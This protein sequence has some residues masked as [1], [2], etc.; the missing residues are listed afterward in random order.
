MEE[1][2]SDIISLKIKADRSR[3]DD[4]F[5]GKLLGALTNIIAGEKERLVSEKMESMTI[6]GKKSIDKKDDSVNA[7]VD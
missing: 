2:K 6:S 5:L 1:L 7:L 4:A 3:E